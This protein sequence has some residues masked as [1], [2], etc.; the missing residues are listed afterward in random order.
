MEILTAAQMQHADRI[1]I[2]AGT[3]SLD[4]M[5]RAGIAT[6]E[7]LLEA[8]PDLPQRGALIVCGKGNN[9]GDGL[10]ILRHLRHHGVSARAII[11][12]DAEDISSDS[13]SNLQRARS[14]SCDVL[15]AVTE[16]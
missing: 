8:L 11:L 3:P 5:E 9:G 6:V 15:H 4:L 16:I 13:R 12:A 14:E 7:A 1:T 10:V 2:E